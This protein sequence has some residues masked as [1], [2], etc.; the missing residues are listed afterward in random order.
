MLEVCEELH[1]LRFGTLQPEDR[2]LSVCPDGC[3][4]HEGVGSS[5]QQHPQ[6]RVEQEHSA[7]L[8]DV[9]TL[10][11]QRDEASAAALS[12]IVAQDPDPTVRGEAA[13][14][15]GKLG[16]AESAM[17]I[18]MALTDQDPSVRV[19]AARAL[20]SVEGDQAT[21]ALGGVLMGDSDPRVRREAVRTLATLG[22]EQARW[23]LEAAASDPDTSVRRSVASALA[24]WGK[25]PAA[26]Q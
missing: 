16:E 7:G 1:L 20:G 26:T 21:P 24:R 19:Q 6:R 17:A 25:G 9:R 3:P 23:A 4:T 12:Q 10:T 2:L 13:A 5:G 18:S 8:R 22:T 15:L 11:R 14:A